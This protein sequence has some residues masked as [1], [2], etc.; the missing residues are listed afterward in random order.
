MNN[1]VRTDM[2]QVRLVVAALALHGLLVRGDKV[3]RVPNNLRYVDEAFAIADKF[4]SESEA[5]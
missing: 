5:K 2:S 4:I 3:L 1:K